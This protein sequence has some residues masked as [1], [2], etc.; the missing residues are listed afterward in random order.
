MCFSFAICLFFRGELSKNQTVHI[1]VFWCV[2]DRGW[3]S[4]FHVQHDGTLAKLQDDSGACKV[5]LHHC[6]D[7]CSYRGEEGQWIISVAQPQVHVGGEVVLLGGLRGDAERLSDSVLGEVQVA[8]AVGVTFPDGHRRVE[9]RA[10]VPQPQQVVVPH[11]LQQRAEAR[12][13]LLVKVVI[14][15]VRVEVETPQGVWA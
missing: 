15:A 1:C 9:H 6:D 10:A 3:G 11:P 7:L 14:V 12:V 2:T 8:D 5:K 4:G 13:V